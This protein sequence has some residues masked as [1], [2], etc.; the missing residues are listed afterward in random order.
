MERAARLARMGDRIVSFC[1]AVLILLM[2]LY[3][4]YSLWDTAR[5]FNGAFLSDDL[6]KFKPSGSGDSNPTLAE[7]QQINPDC[8]AWLTIDDT[9]IDYPVVHGQDNATYINTDVYGE[10]ALSGAIFLDYRN[11]PDFSD[12]YSLVY[13]HHMENGAM[14][15]DVVEFMQQA[16]FDAHPSGTLYLPDSSYTITIFACVQ[17]DAYDSVIYNPEMET[18]DVSTLLHTIQSKAICSRDIGITAEDQIIGLSTCAENETNGRVIIFGR[19]D[20]V[21]EAPKED[22]NQ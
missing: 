16:Y 21:N 1:A 7:L 12:P 6:L 14:F 10:F 11:A 8:C 20:R 17:A 3:G 9:H 13:G 18:R 5:V 4:G 19:L 2:L 15:G 22:P